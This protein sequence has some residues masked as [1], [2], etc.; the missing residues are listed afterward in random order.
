MKTA[1]LIPAILAP[2][3]VWRFYRRVRRH[4]GRQTLRP[5]RMGLSIAL[6]TLTA[7]LVGI[8]LV[9]FGGTPWTLFGGILL[10]LV[11]GFVG[12]KLTRFEVIAEERFYT[13]NPY[14]GTVVILILLARIVYRLA[15]FY[16]D[17]GIPQVSPTTFGQSP[18]TLGVLGL[19]LGYYIFYPGLVLFRF[20]ADVS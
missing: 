20:N 8:L 1:P 12:Y 19:T 2:L 7:A 11:L 9:R 18:L 10:G 13:P 3:I 17:S 4:I 15:L 14:L 6:M 5:V 16:S